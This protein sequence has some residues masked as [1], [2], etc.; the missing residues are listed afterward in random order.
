MSKKLKDVT[1]KEISFVDEPA[2]QIPFLI[3]KRDESSEELNKLEEIFMKFAED[4]LFSKSELAELDEAFEALDDLDDEKV[5]A[6]TTLLSIAGTNQ[7]MVEKKEV[8]WP[9]FCEDDDDGD[10]VYYE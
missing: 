9:S 4:G 10:E 7:G 6:I 5:D 1:L 8:L 3:V 2:N